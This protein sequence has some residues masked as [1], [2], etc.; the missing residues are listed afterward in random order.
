[1]RKLLKSTLL[2]VICS[3]FITNTTKAQIF[4]VPQVHK[5][6]SSNLELKKGRIIID[7]DSY[8]KFASQIDKLKELLDSRYE[9]NFDIS[10]GAYPGEIPALS[11]EVS[12]N[13]TLEPQGYKI[14]INENSIKVVAHDHS[15]LFYGIQSLQ[16]LLDK[17]NEI[18]R[19]QTI[20]D[21]PDF[22]RRGIMLD[23]SRDKV[24][25]MET[26]KLLIDR[27][28]SWK[29]NEVQLYVEHTFAYKNHKEVWKDASPLTADEILELD[30]YCSDR[31]IDLVPNQNS[32]GHMGRWL[33]HE[34]YFYLSERPGDITSDNWILHNRRRTLCAVNPQA[35]EFMDS[36]YAEYLPNFSSK[37]ANIGGDEPYELGYGKSKEMCEKMGKS[38]VYLNYIK[39][40]TNRVKQYGKQPQ[41]W[42]DIVNKH[43]ELI[44]LMP[45]DVICMIW[46]YRP[47]H[48]FDKQCSRFHEEQLPFY[49]CP[50]TS[51]WRT[52]IGKTERSKLN[53]QNAAES[54]KRY[55]AVGMLNTNW[56]D[57]GHM[58][59]IST[60]FPSFIYGAGMSWSVEKNRD[61]NLATLTNTLIYQDP[62]KKMGE[63]LLQLT[64]AYMGGKGEDQAGRPYFDMFNRVDVFFSD[65]YEVKYY[66]PELLPFMRKEIAEATEKIM[67]AKPTSVDGQVSKDELLIAAKLATW[68]C[69]LI[70]ARLDAKDQLISNIPM[71]RR[72]K[73]SKQL[74]EIIK[75]YKPMWLVRN[76]E[77]GLSD[78]V[79]RLSFVSKELVK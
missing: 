31:M 76:R 4:P 56:G 11:F 25:T 18:V 52:I 78:S 32:L 57:M 46:G 19:C 28:A 29:I 42:G 7:T 51:G 20:H 62:T 59:P 63:G 58:Q 66:D 36:L 5:V 21:W 44:P 70:E 79:E 35:V 27:F 75:E 1:M 26:I 48:P 49:V 38:H 10:A 34:D 68:G 41:M 50:G 17:R 40:V 69:E 45:K 13:T 15:G 43:P 6:S 2:L 61:I 72:K 60:A 16:M 71:K 67:E 39:Q 8:K 3:L 73:L 23:V 22:D 24:P 77:G 53:I 47:N 33:E 64:N 14:K 12:P 37:Y 65:K 54:G 30:K 55:G 9:N 74:D